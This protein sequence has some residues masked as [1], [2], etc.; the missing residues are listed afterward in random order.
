M[1]DH[2]AVMYAGRVVEPRPWRRSS[3]H[4][5]HPYAQALLGSIPGMNDSRQRLA[6]IDRQPPDLATLPPGCAF[7][8]RCPSSFD[9]CREA[10]PPDLGLGDSCKVRCWLAAGGSS[11][12]QVD[13]RDG[14]AR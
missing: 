3:R 6:V 5:P 10:S 14:A 2:L 9:R 13:A 1:C 11:A 12:A 4:R 8:P 7:A